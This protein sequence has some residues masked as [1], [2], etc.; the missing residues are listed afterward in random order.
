MSIFDKRENI[1][2]YEYPE[3]MDY[4]RSIQKAYWLVDE[5]NFTNDIQDFKTSCSTY[6][7]SVIEKSML[8][9]AQIEVKVKRFW[10]DISKRMDK[11]EIAIVGAI[12]SESEARH[13]T[14]YS[15]LLSLLGLNDKFEHLGDIKEIQ[16]RVDYLNKYLD[17]TRS[18]DNRMYTK[19]LMLFSLFIEHVSLFSQFLIMQSFNKHKNILSGFSNV[20]DATMQEENIHG[21]FGAAI[22]NIIKKEYPDY[23][24]EELENI[25][26][27]G[28]KKAY[29]AEEAIIDWIMDNQDLDFLTRA[30]V[31]EY[32]K[33]RFNMSL[34]SCGFKSIFEVNKDLLVNLEWIDVQLYSNKEDDF[35]YKKS[36]SYNKFSKS[37]TS[38]DLF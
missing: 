2:P 30:E 1:K 24:D 3:L 17:G 8:A 14:A 21:L 19:S 7:Q 10:G 11:P 33:N 29:K 22:V 32:I 27:S 23:F 9:I 12:F 37:V 5:F 25:I 4:G 26:Y 28:C 38:E 36:T 34:E 6:E 18:R 13:L 31:K 20:V 15:E 35:F 16:G